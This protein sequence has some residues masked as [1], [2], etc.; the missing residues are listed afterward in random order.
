ME[1]KCS[2]SVVNQGTEA[3]VEKGGVRAKV[4]K[5]KVAKKSKKV[6]RS[7]KVKEWMRRR[8]GERYCAWMERIDKYLS[9]DESEGEVLE[10]GRSLLMRYGYCL[11][12]TSDAADE[13]SSV[14]L[15]G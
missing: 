10:D 14:D 15:G 6:E 12:Y 2:D 5:V 3:S 1:L 4:K 13:R 7:V 11:L 9:S 8:K